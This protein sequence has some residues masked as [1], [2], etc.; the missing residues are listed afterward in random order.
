MVFRH[1]V[2]EMVLASDLKRHF[3]VLDA[4]KARVSQG[5]P[6]DM[7]RDSD[8]LLLLQMALKAAD[9]GHAVKPLAIHKEWA[10][11]ANEEFYN[12]GDAERALSLQVSP[13]MDR[14][15][16]NVPRSQMSFFQFLVLPL[17]ELWVKAFPKSSPLLFHMTACPTSSTGSTRCRPA[18]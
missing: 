4:F 17:F 10:R 6:W 18:Y 8:R 12:Q 9:I 11:R 15:N 1:T 14:M 13:F 7:E 2:I 5:T 16:N 3:G